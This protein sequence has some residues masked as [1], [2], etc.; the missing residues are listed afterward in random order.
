MLPVFLSTNQFAI[1]GNNISQNAGFNGIVATSGQAWGTIY[2]LGNIGNEP[3][4]VGDKILVKDE[5]VCR[6]AWDNGTWNIY[7]IDK[8][9]VTED[10]AL[11]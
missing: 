3:P 1:Y 10:T 2:M 8:I 9:I 6:L 4:R 5:P 11:P 7:T